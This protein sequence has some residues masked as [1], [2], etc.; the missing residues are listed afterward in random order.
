MKNLNLVKKGVTHAGRFHTDDVL[1]AV[2]LKNLNPDIIF[3]RVIK[4]DYDDTMEDVIVFDVGN[5]EFDHHN[6]DK[7]LNDF[8]HPY[9]AFGKLWKAYGKELLIK[10]G[11]TNIEDGFKLFNSSYVQKVDEGDNNGYIYVKNF[12]ENK[13]ITD[14]NPKWY[15]YEGNENA[16]DQQFELAVKTAYHIFDNW[17]RLVYMKVEY[18]DIEKEIWFNALRK[19]ENGIVILEKDIN[20]RV[21]LKKYPVSNLK[22]VI[23]KSAREG[24][25]VSSVDEKKLKI[26]SSEY[27]IFTH[28]SGFMGIANT[29][30][31]AKLAAIKCII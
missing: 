29:L 5:G 22:I 11:F 17:L 27:L 7:E 30:E 1:S 20:W 15:E 26:S 24:Y 13:I 19:S 23:S 9:S 2:L 6:M 12:V 4:C 31:E 28:H 8:G 16:F 14:F 18:D 21:F 25:S 10:K 3:E